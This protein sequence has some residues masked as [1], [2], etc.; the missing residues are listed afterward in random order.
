MFRKRPGKDELFQKFGT[1]DDGYWRSTSPTPRGTYYATL[2]KYKYDNV[3]C[4][5][6]RSPNVEVP[7]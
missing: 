5:K 1:Y 7:G 6:A 4:K 2:K 3:T